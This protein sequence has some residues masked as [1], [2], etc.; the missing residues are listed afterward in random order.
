MGHL[1]SFTIRPAP[2]ALAEVPRPELPLSSADPPPLPPPGESPTSLP[3]NDPIPLADRGPTDQSSIHNSSDQG[4]VG[5][6]SNA[7]EALADGVTASNNR[8]QTPVPENP[9]QAA[10]NGEA[11]QPSSPQAAPSPDSPDLIIQQ[12]IVTVKKEP[13]QNMNSPGEVHMV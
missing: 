8:I 6:T 4:T 10:D 12:V 11:G 3:D 1:H 7:L 5:S 13:S 9:I 2:F